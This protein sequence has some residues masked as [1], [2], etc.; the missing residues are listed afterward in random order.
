M[1]FLYIVLPL[2][3]VVAG[4][5]YVVWG[6][7]PRALLAGAIASPVLVVVLRFLKPYPSPQGEWLYDFVFFLILTTPFALLGMGLG[8]AVRKARN[9]DRYTASDKDVKSN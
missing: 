5:V 3:I 6:K 2:P 7:C 9:R 8:Y 1:F 4:T